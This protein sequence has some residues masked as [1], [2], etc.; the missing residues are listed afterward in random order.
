MPTVKQ[1]SREPLRR[2]LI[3]AEAIQL[4]KEVGSDKLTMRALAS[5]LGVS[6]MA[7]Y[8]HVDDKEELLR[9]IG[10]DILGRIELPDSESAPWQELFL[11]A[12]HASMDALCSVPGLSAV[13]L[14]SKLLENARSLVVFSLRQFE[15][16]GLSNADAQAA[17]AGVQLLCLGRLVVQENMNFAAHGGVSRDAEL[18]GYMDILRSD[19]TFDRALLALLEP[20][21]TDA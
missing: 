10:D 19:T 15:R 18:S 20:Y 5:R 17:Y 6:A 13:L 21:V 2:E 4:L 8:H 7:L 12:T 14:S 11:F 3:A 1:V 16:A 9:L